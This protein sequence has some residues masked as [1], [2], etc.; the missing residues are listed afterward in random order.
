[1]DRIRAILGNIV[2]RGKI[3]PPK[4]PTSKMTKSLDLPLDKKYSPII[5]R[6]PKEK[7][8]KTYPS[9]LSAHGRNP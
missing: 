9:I 3:I 8:W 6:Q 4:K 1:V 7:T 2:S 5:N